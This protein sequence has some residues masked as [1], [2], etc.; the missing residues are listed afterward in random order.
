MTLARPD[1]VVGCA[2]LVD[3]ESL[4]AFL[5]SLSQDGA[6][7]VPIAVFA[8]LLSRPGRLLALDR[9]C[10]HLYPVHL[11]SKGP[12]IRLALLQLTNSDPAFRRKHQIFRYTFPTVFVPGQHAAARFD[13]GACAPR[14]VQENRSR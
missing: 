8:V 3:G 14:F 10:V 11:A 6:A 12:A 2:R 13:V 9:F 5:V 1:A 7:F 4:R